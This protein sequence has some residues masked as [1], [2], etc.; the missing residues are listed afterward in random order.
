M[1]RLLTTCI[2]LLAIVPAL[3]KERK[4]TPGVQRYVFFLHQRFVELYGP[5]AMHPEYGKAEY[6]AILDRFRN[7]GFTV[8]SERRPANAD[9]RLY[10]DR[11]A[12]QIDSLRR[13]GVAPEHITVIGTSKGGY[14]AQMVSSQLKDPRVNYVFIGC[15]RD[16]DLETLPDINFCGNILS[17]YEESD[18]LGVSAVKRVELSKLK[19]SRFKEIELHTG[20][21]HGFLY[22]PLDEWIQPSIQWASSNY[23]VLTEWSIKRSIDSV[24]ASMPD[25]PFNGTILIK[26][27]DRIIHSGTYGY[28]DLDK[29]TSFTGNSQF[30]IGS[31][32]KQFTAAIVLQEMERGHL[33][34]QDPIK[35]YLPQLPASWADS[36][37]IYHLLTHTHGIVARN[38][39][40]AFRPGTNT[41]Y[42]RGNNIGYMLLSEIVEKT[43]GK[44]FADLSA[45]LFRKCGMKNT[46]HP[47]IKQYHSLVNGYTQ[48]NAGKLVFD[49]GRFAPAPAAGCLIS[50]AADLVLWNECLHG[51]KV[52][53]PTT[54]TMMTTIQPHVVRQHPTWGKTEY[55]LGTT[56]LTK[57]NLL[58]YGQT[59]YTAG[60]PS[61]NYY[62]PETKTSIVVLQNT[63]HTPKKGFHEVFH[64]HVALL[65][66]LREQLQPGK[67]IPEKSVYAM[68]ADTLLYR[69]KYPQHQDPL[70]KYPLVIYLHGMG[71]R[72]SDNETPL[73]RTASHLTD[74]VRNARFPCFVLVPQCPS[75]DTWVSFPDSPS[76]LATTD[77]PTRSARLVLDLI[78]HLLEVRDI[79]LSRIYLTGYSMGG[80][81]TFDLM[82]REPG[83]FACG[84]PVA[85]VADT[86]RAAQIKHIPIWAFHGS[87]DNINETKFTL[88]MIDALKR[89]GGSPKV[90]IFPGM[91]H[92]C[93]DSVY[94]DERVWEWMFAQRKN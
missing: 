83:L 26:E 56:I 46:F 80:E 17:I 88:W 12:A 58:Q 94:R 1:R 44:S 32:S 91:G 36:V 25:R 24:L 21:R 87:E 3:T 45:G 5:E 39:P 63:V 40:L 82:T 93:Q 73:R 53:K 74:P 85:S 86:N 69:L 68:G 13:L 31:I 27:G 23:S 35:K 64:Y 4:A 57:N 90:T 41:D 38:Q 2:L 9:E 67:Q 47:A 33:A 55:G 6:H 51:G 89:Q 7:A 70:Q 79:D 29:K 48:N 14:I 78:H 18:T 65:G 37:T 52:L 61:M 60:Y 11:V 19:V 71:A 62:F 84:V 42:E 54:Y 10:A 72:G 77:S 20:L 15:Y 92:N 76:S 75:S 81:G 16:K 22:H 43:S 8:I 49:S 66:M 50:T 59:G 30:V 28:A 34:L